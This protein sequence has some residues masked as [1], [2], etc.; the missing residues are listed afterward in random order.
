MS[1][2][3]TRLA[4]IAEILPDPD[5]QATENARRSMH[6]ARASAPWGTGRRRGWFS[7][8]P[9]TYMIAAALALVIG[10]GALAA[11]GWG[12]SDL[13]PFGDDDRSAFVLPAT[14]ILPGGYERTRPPRYAE[15]PER[16]SLLFPA[17]VGYTEALS[18]YA[19][20]RAAGE[21][22]PAGVVLADPL[23]AGKVVMV[24]PDGRIA[25]DPAAP[26]G[27][28]ATSGLVTTMSAPFNGRAIPIARC[29]L[30]VGDDDPASP[31]CDQSGVRRTY[32]T[33]GVNGR[34]IPSPNQEALFDRVLPASTQLSVL[35]DPAVPRVRLPATLPLRVP[36]SAK[37][38][39]PRFGRL[40]LETPDVRLIVAE[41]PPDRLCFIAQ[42]KKVGGAGISCGPRATFLNRGADLSGGRYMGGPYRLSG[43]VGDGI[44]RVTTDD[45]V[46]VP[47]VH[48]VFTMLPGDGV[49]VLTFSGPVGA[50]RIALPRF[51]DGPRRF[52]PDRSKERELLGI[53]LA[54]GGHASI[55]VAPNR[56]GGQCVWVYVNGNAGSRGCSRPGDEPLN[57][58]IITGGFIRRV[59]RVPSL[60]Q[61]R[62]APQVG[63]IELG[64]ADGTT[65]RLRPTEGFIL[66]QVPAVHLRPGHQAVSITTFDRQGVALVHEEVRRPER[67]RP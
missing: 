9:R 60:F 47:V 54:G 65:K 8:G 46:V 57:Y 52:T 12:I 51:G 63:S 4:A 6:A 14:D 24:R 21:I 10:G 55:R 7:R 67:G 49:R 66:Y 43:L 26:F 48:N 23:P 3:E 35:D 15:L 31:P 44:D 61:G 34:W 25:L 37:S 13:P 18:E 45:R 16:P 11:G 41:V 40:A 38:T 2:L 58:D 19:T 20:A 32:V 62:F 28:S 50:F 27:Y 22:L 56:G 29:Q 53:D 39:Q 5:E 36:G 59:D 1:D 30:L 17:G 42:E 64:F 33:E